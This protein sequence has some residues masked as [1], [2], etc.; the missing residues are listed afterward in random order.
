MK[1]LMAITGLFLV[2]FLLFHMFGNL[3]LLIDFNEFD[4]YSHTLRY[5]MYPI[6]PPYFFIWVFRITLLLSALL[7][8]LSATKLTLA[9]YDATGRARYVR[10]RYLQGSFAA[11]TMIW[12]GILVAV[13]VIFHLLQFTAQVVTVGYAGD[14]L[15]HERVVMG[16]GQPWL[17]AIYGL[18]MIAVCMH[19]WHG[20]YSAFCTLGVRVGSGTEKLFRVCAW[21]VSVLL[22]LG[23]MIPPMMIL[24]G[25]VTL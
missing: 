19:I 9:H 5:F 1:A 6:L 15:P 11:R 8:I 3:K 10:R 12:G 2:A 24:L 13:F 18:A 4:E 17:V 22:F 23:F 25:V 7:H 14:A 16:F 20:F 21:A